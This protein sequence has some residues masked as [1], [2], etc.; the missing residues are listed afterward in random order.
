MVM[1]TVAAAMIHRFFRMTSTPPT[2]RMNQRKYQG[3]FRGWEPSTESMVT[4][5]IRGETKPRT[6]SRNMSRKLSTR[7]SLNPLV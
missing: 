2:P 6:S 3:V 5:R 7:G 4:A 1:P